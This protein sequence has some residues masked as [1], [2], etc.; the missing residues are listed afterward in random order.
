MEILEKNILMD[1]EEGIFINLSTGVKLKLERKGK[2]GQLIL[3]K[4]EEKDVERAFQENG[5]DIALCKQKVPTDSEI[6]I[7][8]IF[9]V[10]YIKG[11]KMFE[12]LKI[13]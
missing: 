13:M 8:K 7:F 6:N 4:I 3:E 10:E 1:R 12:N 11:N 5:L 2:E 9:I